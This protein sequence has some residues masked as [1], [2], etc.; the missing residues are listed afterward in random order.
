MLKNYLARPLQKKEAVNCYYALAKELEDLGEYKQSF[1]ALRSGAAIQRQLIQFN[2]PDELKNIRDII[3]TFQ[4]TAFAGIP[5]SASEETP[6]FI[7]GM[8]RTGTTL[9]ERIISQ[10]EG[11]RSGEETYDFTLAFSSIINSHIAAN[12]DRNLNPLS[13]ALEV[14]YNEIARKYQGNLQGMFGEASRY[15]D[16]TP[17]NFLYCGLIKKAFPRARIVHLVRDPMD[18]CFAVFKTLFARAYFFSY[19]LDE[20]GD[21]YIAYRQL[22]DHWHQLMPGA[23]LDVRYEELVSNPLDVSRQIADYVGL[24]WSSELIEVQNVTGQSSTASAAQVREP[25]YTTSV[26]RWRHFEAE[27]EPVRRKLAAANIVDENGN[28]LI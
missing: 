13:A 27:L 3:N 25:I 4:P 22:M 8:P 24:N 28:S 9:V 17:F 10:D 21:Y 6:V 2:L 11:I 7:V 19:D 15:L 16:K 26:S 18:T 5:D 23:I 12:P 20:L 14:D 1:S